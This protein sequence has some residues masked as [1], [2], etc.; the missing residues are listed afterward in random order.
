[1][2]CGQTQKISKMMFNFFYC[3][4]KETH[5]NTILQ[6]VAKYYAALQQNIMEIPFISIK[7]LQNWKISVKALSKRLQKL[8]IITIQLHNCNYKKI[9]PECKVL[10]SINAF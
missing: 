9:T 1:V 5:K 8:T 3:K 6:V 2:D 10:I 7:A 4:I